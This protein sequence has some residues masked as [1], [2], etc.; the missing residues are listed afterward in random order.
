MRPQAVPLLAVAICG[1][2]LAAPLLA[3]DVDLERD[4]APAD[5]DEFLGDLIPQFAVLEHIEDAGFRFRIR[6]IG[7]R[8]GL[9]AVLAIE[10]FDPFFLESGYSV[11]GSQ[12]HR[13]GLLFGDEENAGLRTALS[14]RRDAE[15]SFWGVGSGTLEADRS[16]FR[17]DKIEAAAT[18]WMRLS[19]RLQLR[20]GLAFEDNRVA[21]G[22]DEDLPNV[23]STFGAG[24]V[25]GISERVEFLRL[26]TSATLD[27]TGTAGF[28][29]RGS[30]FHVGT[31]LFRGVDGTDSD[32]HRFTGR[33][34]YYLPV[35]VMSMFAFRGLVEINRLDSGAG[36]P[37]FDLSRMGGSRNGPRSFEGGRFRDRDGLSLMSEFRQE[38]ARFDR[39]RL[40]GFIFLDEGGVTHSLGSLSGSDLRTSYGLGL[41]LTGIEGFATIGYVAFGEEGTQ[42]ALRTH[43]PF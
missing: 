11:R 40:Q 13:G 42:F 10:R 32:F 41:R 24:S 14:F 18:G 34:R 36:I 30:W 43:W 20:A 33:A 28:Q 26:E 15:D 1:L 27:L 31:A 29:R 8:S 23:Q 5:A 16:D 9:G 22:G 12:H 7:P 2:G 25:F 4:A 38:I 17:R 37:F 39:R 21:G 35:G 19:E 6:S 3:Q